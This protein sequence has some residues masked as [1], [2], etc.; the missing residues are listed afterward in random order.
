MVIVFARAPVTGRVKTRLAAR[1]GHA[2]AALLHRRLIDAA[3]RSALAARCGPVELHA[4]AKHSWLKALCRK[5]GVVLRLQKGADLGERMANA[6]RAALRRTPW[7]LLMGADCPELGPRELARARRWLVG[8]A[9]AVIAPAH[10][11]GY[12]LIGLARPADF[13]FRG[14][15]WGS[16]RVYEETILKAKRAGRRMRALGPVGDIDR[17]EDLERLRAL[18]LFSASRRCARR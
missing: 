16:E 10:D 6:T 13:L 8:G 4:T 1:L 17:P 12:A 15:A 3:L 14:V 18:R 9:D 5:R 11:G 2:R 7:V